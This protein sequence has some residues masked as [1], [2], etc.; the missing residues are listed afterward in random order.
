M[1]H[2]S[3]PKLC[4]LFVIFTKVS[5]GFHIPLPLVVSSNR[6]SS[7]VV[8]V[9]AA[10]AAAK[11]KR[12]VILQKEPSLTFPLGGHV[13]GLDIVAS[14]FQAN[15]RVP[16]LQ[17]FGL[18]AFLFAV[19][20]QK[21]LNMLTPTGLMHAFVLATLLWTSIGW[22]GWTLCVLYLFLGQLVTKVKFADKEKRGIAEKRGGRRG[23]GGVWYVHIFEEEN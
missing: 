15:G 19:L 2:N 7:P 14:I 13:A 23:P 18:N 1:I 4:F 10:A 11:R 17:S 22:K 8:V 3:I 5:F 16:L 20:S 9:V 6:L 12:S 21:L